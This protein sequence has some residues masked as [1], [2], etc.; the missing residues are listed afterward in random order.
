[1]PATRERRRNVDR[2]RLSVRATCCHCHK[3]LCREVEYVCETLRSTIGTKTPSGSI[4][5]FY[6]CIPCSEARPC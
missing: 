1:M 2:M 6:M 3:L 5:F 4:S